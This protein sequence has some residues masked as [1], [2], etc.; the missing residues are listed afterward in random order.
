M[1]VRRSRSW[2]SLSSFASVCSQQRQGASTAADAAHGHTHTH[3]QCQGRIENRREVDQRPEPR[4]VS[5]YRTRR[6]RRVA[7]R[8]WH[9]EAGCKGLA[10][11]D[12]AGRGT[13]HLPAFAASVPSCVELT[14]KKPHSWYKLHRNAVSCV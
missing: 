9:T 3:T 7:G 12:P 1:A 8:G 10:P 2:L 6:R 11:T 14:D 4:A 5:Q 13:E